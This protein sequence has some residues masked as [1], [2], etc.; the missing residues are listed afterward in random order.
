MTRCRPVRNPD[1]SDRRSSRA[2]AGAAGFEPA[3]A[4]T[5]N[6]AQPSEGRR[7]LRPIKSLADQV[8]GATKIG[9][10]FGTQREVGRP[11]QLDARRIVHH[12]DDA[13]LRVSMPAKHRQHLIDI[14]RRA[15]NRSPPLVWG[16]V[17]SARSSAA[18]PAGADVRT[19]SGPFAFRRSGHDCLAASDLAPS[20]SGTAVQ[21]IRI[22]Q[23]APSFT[24]W[25]DPF[26][27]P[28]RLGQQTENRLVF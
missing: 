28:S 17:K 23:P 12:A 20:I 6:R 13:G 8:G 16:S 21:S 7:N 25:R 14:G 24:S 11:R 22:P 9:T 5:K 27:G 19:I 3:N 18:K 26:S 4:G 10:Q 2:L 15:R 1:K